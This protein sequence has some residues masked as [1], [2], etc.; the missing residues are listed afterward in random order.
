MVALGQQGKERN[1][2]GAAA[3]RCSVGGGGRIG[4][5]GRLA[6]ELQGKVG[7]MVGNSGGWTAQ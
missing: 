6:L 7:F 2:W 5:E 1:A 4:S 3:F